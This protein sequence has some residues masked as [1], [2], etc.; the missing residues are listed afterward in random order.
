MTGERLPGPVLVTGATGNVGGALINRLLATGHSVRALVRSA[1]RAAKILPSEVTLF[2]GDITDTASIGPTVEG[3]GTV[4]HA[5]GLPEQWNPDPD[6]FDRVN[7]QG[8]VNVADA[9]LGAGV[10]CFIHVSTIDVFMWTPGVPFDETIDPN[11]KQTRYEQ[12]K[13]AADRSVVE[14]MDNGLPARFACPAGVFGPAPTITPGANQLL[15][16]LSAN[17]IPMLLPGGLPMV[18]NEDV[19]DGIIRIGL[20]PVGTRA[21]LSGPYKTLKDI[22]EMVH[23]DT[24]TSKVPRVLHA[25]FAHLVSRVGEAR[26]QRSGKAPL[27]PAGAL[28]F[29]EC[30]VVPDARHARNDL[31]WKTTPTDEAVAR[32]VVWLQAVAAGEPATD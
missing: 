18:F 5:A 3:S 22:A 26:A 20:G 17:E 7:H 25:W 21:I 28:H 11:L 6:I 31:G 23:Y 12:S 10:E 15:A 19:A 2:E 30:H 32:T 27:I 13:Q 8:T 16:D 14:R 9:S 4:I 29:L 24:G 1:E